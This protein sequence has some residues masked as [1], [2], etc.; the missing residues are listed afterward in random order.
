M[1]F[2]AELD[3]RPKLHLPVVD[4]R[5][6]ERRLLNHVGECCGTEDARNQ[7]QCDSDS[8]VHAGATRCACASSG[9]RRHLSFDKFLFCI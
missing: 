3:E 6:I 4:S 5:S 8:S 1:E 9:S 2:F 7:G